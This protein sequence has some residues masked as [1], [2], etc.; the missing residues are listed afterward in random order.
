MLPDFR[1][2]QPFSELGRAELELLSRHSRRLS[3]PAGRWLLRPGRIL[4]RAHYL[5][6]GSVATVQPPSVI[7]AGADAAS[8][9]LEPRGAGLRTLTSCELLQV[10]TSVLEI[11]TATEKPRLMDVGETDDCW[12]ARFLGSELMSSLEPILWQAVLNRLIP[13]GVENGQYIIREG[14]EGA[15]HCYV[16]TRGSALVERAGATLARLQPGE[17]FGEDALLTHRP[18]NA[19]VR[20]GSDGQ[21]MRL[22][23]SDFK[24]FLVDVLFQGGFQAPPVSERSQGRVLLRLGS[25]LDLRDRIARLDP[26]AEYVVSSRIPEVESLAIFLMRKAGLSAWAAPHA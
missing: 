13:E 6:N 19:S 5:L 2:F 8:Q 14:E 10:P 22:V 20:M 18:R 7:R 4:R 3:V 1:R 24:R 11:L 21:V 26:R 23:I 12:Q 16:L 17:L 15:R 9:A 25:G